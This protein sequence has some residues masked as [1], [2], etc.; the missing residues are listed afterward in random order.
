MERGG[1]GFYS[2]T[3]LFGGGRCES[4]NR[5]CSSFHTDT[6]FGP[7]QPRRS[8][9]AASTRNALFF[10]K[11][12]HRRRGL[13]CDT[14]LGRA[15]ISVAFNFPQQHLPHSL[16]EASHHSDGGRCAFS[17]HEASCVRRISPSRN[18]P[19]DVSS[20]HSQQPLFG[21]VNNPHRRVARGQATGVMA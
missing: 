14:G 8:T 18:N 15:R 21:A 6:P 2:F 5:K 9:G 1:V 3:S 7:S 16:G 17:P 10:Q 4:L 20:D 13:F 12:L 19:G 11:D